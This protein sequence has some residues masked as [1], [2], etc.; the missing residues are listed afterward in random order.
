MTTIYFVRHAHAPFSLTDFRTRSLSEKGMNDA[1]RVGEILREVSFDCAISSSSP[2]AVETIQPVVDH[3]GLPLSCHD[4]LIEL[5]L[6]GPEVELTLE[7]VHK[8]IGNVL[9]NKTHKLSSGESR[10]EV[11]D[12]AIP[13]FRQ[14]LAENQGKT[15]LF[16]T[17]G[18]I[19]TILLDVFGGVCGFEFWKQ[20]T[21][22]DIYKVEFDQDQIV[23]MERCWS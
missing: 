6:R 12:R 14:L 2:R 21:K 8:E 4:E 20:L 10:Q 5:K 7:G 3:Q 15:V 22:P 19:M 11:E 17:H 23:H 9:A 16:G 1:Q 13:V 18:M